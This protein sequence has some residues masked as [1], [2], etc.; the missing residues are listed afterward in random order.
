M[1]IKVKQSFFEA[2]RTSETISDV[3]VGILETFGL[4]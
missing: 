2:Y 3:F 1:F 4:W